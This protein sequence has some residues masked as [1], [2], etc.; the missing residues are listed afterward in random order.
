MSGALQIVATPIGNL[1][2]ITLRAL[3]VLREAE[4][5]LAEDTRRTRALLTHHEISTPLAALHAHTGPERVAD[6][7]CRSCALGHQLVGLGGRTVPHG[8][9]M[10]GPQE[11]AGERLA[12]QPESDD[13]H[14]RFGFAVHGSIVNVDTGVKVK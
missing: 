6:R 4:L 13:C 7:R 11:R 1:E 9:G 12:H 2:D 5:V 14:G 3:R 10:P 8:C